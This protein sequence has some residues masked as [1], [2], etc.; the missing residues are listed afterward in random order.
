MKWVAI[1]T[2]FFSAFAKFMFAPLIGKG[3]KLDFITSW[4]T[5]FA[6]GL[7]SALVFY[8]MSEY[9]MKRNHIKKVEKKLMMERTGQVYKRQKNFSKLNR[10]IIKVK[11]SIGQYGLCLFVPLFLS[12]PIGSIICAKFY[13][14]E[15][16]TF[17][18]I[19]FGLAMNSFGL[20]VL[21]YKI[22]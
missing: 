18:I 5:T 20:T 8:F 12:V 22:F 15:K 2:V 4:V 21:F 14:K 9:F 6:G 10:T 7:V 16:N 17:S 19:V 3:F 11:H 13:G 1:T